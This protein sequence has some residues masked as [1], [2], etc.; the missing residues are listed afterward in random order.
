MKSNN[1]GISKI[2]MHCSLIYKDP[3]YCK[4]KY[5]PLIFQVNHSQ[6]LRETPTHTWILAKADGVI[7]SSHCN[8]MA[9][10][11]ESCLHIGA[12]LFFIEAHARIR[13]AKKKHTGFYL[14]L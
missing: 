14:T 13:E 7:L 9:G 5:L 6:R 1:F 8:C 4:A 10:L 3:Y 11:D 2:I 12:T